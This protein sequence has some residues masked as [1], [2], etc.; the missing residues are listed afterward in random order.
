FITHDMGVVAN[1]AD[2]VLVMR[3][4]DQVETGSVSEI[5]DHPKADYSRMLIEAVP[6]MGSLSEEAL[7]PALPPETPKVLEVSNLLKR[8]PI[9]GGAFQRLKGRVHA[10]EGV[11]F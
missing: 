9:R 8:F 1:T 10:V 11:S 6:R 5:F 2:R 4:G 7:P 3:R